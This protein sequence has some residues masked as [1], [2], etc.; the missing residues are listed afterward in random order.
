[1][2][3]LFNKVLYT[4]GMTRLPSLIYLIH[5]TEHVCSAALL[6][7]HHHTETDFIEANKYKNTNS[8]R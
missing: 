5:A 3:I 8:L 4:S 2:Q 7:Y 1:M 6:L